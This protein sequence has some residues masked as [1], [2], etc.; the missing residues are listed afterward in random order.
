MKVFCKKEDLLEGINVVQKAVS[1]KSTL[2]ILEGILIEANESLK[3]TGNDLE[4]GIEAYVQTEV[5]ETGSVVINARIF[6]DIIRRMPDSE[7]MMACD[8]ENNITIE[9]ENSHFEIKGISA[10][11]FPALPSINKENAFKISQRIMKDMIRKTHF[12]ISMDENRPIL[13]GSLVECGEN[14]LTFVS[15]DGF[16]LAKVKE[17]IKNKDGENP[18]LRVVIPGKTLAEIAKIMQPVDDEITIYSTK[19]QI[20]FDMGNCKVIS[21]LLEGEYLNYK[22]IIPQ[23]NETSIKINRA[24]LISSIERAA[25]I[26]TGEERKYP[27][28]FSVKEEKLVLTS[29][30][31]LGA[32]KEEISIIKEGNEIEI[33]FNPRYFIDALKV[34][35]EENVNIYFTSDVGPCTIKPTEGEDYAY[36]ILPVRR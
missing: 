30:T 15:I 20:L 32:V 26:I 22:S 6:G 27:V 4:I 11:S 16:R 34:L 28:T 25:L 21:R 31:D 36:L 7:I 24:G 10:E 17:N 23:E 8:S 35:E 29:K 2:Q 3:L 12:A 33:V 5:G 13:T 19:N 1:T 9:C 14:T 18:V